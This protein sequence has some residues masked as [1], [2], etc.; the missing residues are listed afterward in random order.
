MTRQTTICFHYSRASRLISIIF[1]YIILCSLKSQV[2][3]FASDKLNNGSFATTDVLHPDIFF[4]YSRAP[5]S[6]DQR[7]GYGSKTAI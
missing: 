2:K 1:I 4:R 7:L 3:R 5:I 6:V